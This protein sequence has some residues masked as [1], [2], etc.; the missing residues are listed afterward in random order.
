MSITSTGY[1]IT[2][3][4]ATRG[5][6]NNNGDELILNLKDYLDLN[7]LPADTDPS[8]N[9][10]VLAAR[11][12]STKNSL[13]LV[14]RGAR[15][16]SDIVSENISH[17]TENFASDT[18]PDLPMR[19]QLWFDSAA[20]RLKVWDTAATWQPV[21]SSLAAGLATPVPI[22]VNGDV[23]ATSVDFDGSTG[24]NIPITLATI[25]GLSAGVSYSAPTIK[26]DAKGRV[27]EI[28]A[29]PTIPT[30]GGLAQ[31]AA[32]V[33]KVGD[34]MSGT[35]TIQGVG[36]NLNVVNG[37]VKEAG[38]DLMPAGAIIMWSGTALPGGWKL[39]DGTNGTPDLRNRFIMGTT[40]G[41]AGQTGGANTQ[42]VNTGSAGDHTHSLSIASDGGHNHGGVTGDTALSV[43]QM[44]SHSHP[45]GSG[46]PIKGSGYGYS[47][48]Q[49]V[50]PGTL[51][52]T[53]A[54]GG[55]AGHSHPINTAG[56]HTHA[57]SSLSSGGAHS[58]SV[59]VDVRPS[60]YALVF[61]QKA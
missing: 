10:A 49:G 6:L 8:Y 51:S 7:P 21:G 29:G 40:L 20:N 60:Y 44:P 46:V 54:V 42:S 13:K 38:N 59:S 32:V 34:T 17:L 41:S 37:K 15:N 30:T 35:L 14:R 27:V 43:A 12:D 39:C 23:V 1:T 25:P 33:H 18:A 3:S 50:T 61:I 52:Q 31:D 9:A 2:F 36:A 11:Y 28:S 5:N 45:L 58:H 4:D 22:G 24:V 19:G 48:S 16:Y 26:V 55:G 47:G 53:D 57:G 56:V